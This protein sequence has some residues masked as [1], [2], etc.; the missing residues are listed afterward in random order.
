MQATIRRKWRG[1]RIK[2]A[3]AILAG[4]SALF[5]TSAQAHLVER[6]SI[7]SICHY[8]ESYYVWT[9]GEPWVVRGRLRPSHADKRVVLQRSKSG[10]NWY[11]FQT[12]RTNSDGGYAFRGTAPRNKGSR[13]YVNLRV[14]MPRQMGHERQSSPSIYVDMNPY[15]RC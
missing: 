14:V 11:R 13:W 15:A 10:A 12:T 9:P 2:A 1:R 5:A 4:A 3:C 6:I 8:E 7:R